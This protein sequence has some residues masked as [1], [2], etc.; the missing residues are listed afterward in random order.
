VSRTKHSKNTLGKEWWSARPYSM[1]STGTPWTKF[2]KRLTHKLERLWA[3][4]A[5]RRELDEGAE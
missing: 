2:F 1:T 4:S 3:K 5:I